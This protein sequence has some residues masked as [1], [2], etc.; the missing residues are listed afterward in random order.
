MLF[1][2]VFYF[3]GIRFHKGIHV[4]R[5]FYLLIIPCAMCL[6]G[7]LC[8]TPEFVSGRNLP[9]KFPQIVP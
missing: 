7:I 8:Q 9:W 4:G 3:L 2:S 1:P 6:I 5:A